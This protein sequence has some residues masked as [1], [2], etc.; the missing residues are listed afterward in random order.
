MQRKY[1]HSTMKSD[2]IGIVLLLKALSNECIQDHFY[3]LVYGA[4]LLSDQ[5]VENSSFR[6]MHE[7]EQMSTR[8]SHTELQL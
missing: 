7:L 8:Y 5:L 2:E 3:L 6:S 4:G 1:G